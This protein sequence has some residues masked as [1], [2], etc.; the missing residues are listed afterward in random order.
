[1]EFG[2][3]TSNVA[4]GQPVFTQGTA[5]VAGANTQGNGSVIPQCLRVTTLSTIANSTQLGIFLAT[6]AGGS[7]GAIGNA[8]RV[9]VAGLYATA[10]SAISAGTAGQAVYVSTAGA[11][12]LTPP[13]PLRIGFCVPLPGGGNGIYVTPTPP[14]AP[15]TSAGLQ[16][17]PV[18]IT[19]ATEVD[20]LI[21]SFTSANDIQFVDC[22]I[23]KNG[24]GSAGDQLAIGV[25]SSPPGTPAGFGQS[26]GSP[27][28][29]LN[30]PDGT[31][32]RAAWQ[33]MSN[34]AG[35]KDEYITL[36]PTQVGDVNC[37]VYLTY[38][39]VD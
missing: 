7:L 36:T 13:T 30:H 20:I 29:N 26:V 34:L 5:T 4:V 15:V 1:M 10:I 24:D 14:N 27:F 17:L 18:S 6:A 3:A 28:M 12:Q 9:R 25:E 8:I 37:T 19:A 32:I 16:V 39:V 11:Y 35:A 33:A 23:V 22:M 2:G 31:M 21:S 38:Y